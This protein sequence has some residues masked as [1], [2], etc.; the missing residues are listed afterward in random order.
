MAA[1]IFLGLFW[2]RDKCRGNYSASN[3][4]LVLPRYL[5][6]DSVCSNEGICVSG[7][8]DAFEGQREG[9]EGYFWGRPP[10]SAASEVIPT[11]L[12]VVGDACSSSMYD[13][14]PWIACGRRAGKWTQKECLS[15]RTYRQTY[16]LSMEGPSS[17]GQW[18]PRTNA[19]RLGVRGGRGPSPG[20]PSDV[21]FRSPSFVVR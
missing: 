14:Q 19:D 4:N 9:E 17:S 2:L 13:L 3:G 11:C 20:I 1:W 21:A 7:I 15:A 5:H 18:K 8:S 10:S 6:T 12:N 16:V